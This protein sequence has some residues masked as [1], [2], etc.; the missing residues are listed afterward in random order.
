MIPSLSL[1]TFGASAIALTSC[2]SK[3]IDPD[4]DPDKDSPYM[5]TLKKKQIFNWIMLGTITQI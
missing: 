3:D 5:V 4:I 1:A 2:S